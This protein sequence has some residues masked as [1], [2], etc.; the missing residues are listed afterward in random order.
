MESS[1]MSFLQSLI[2]KQREATEL[3]SQK[4]QDCQ[5]E[6]SFLGPSIIMR[7]KAG[8]TLDNPLYLVRCR[9]FGAV[10]LRIGI[11][12]EDWHPEVFDD[13]PEG[14]RSPGT[15]FLHTDSGSLVQITALLRMKQGDTGKS[16]D[17]SWCSYND[18]KF[19]E[20]FRKSFKFSG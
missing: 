11:C 16:S 8:S 20:S 17:R 3:D 1:D 4:C 13:V 7:P 9:S 14:H 2:Q 6:G 19:L 12:T 15:N 5:N 10:E 18:T